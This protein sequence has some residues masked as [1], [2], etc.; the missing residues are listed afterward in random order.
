M[1]NREVCIYSLLLIIL[2]TVFGRFLVLTN[3]ISLPS[4]GEPQT[5]LKENES[6][7]VQ[8]SRENAKLNQDIVLPAD[9]E[10]WSTTDQNKMLLKELVKEGSYSIILRIDDKQCIDCIT[11]AMKTIKIATAGSNSVRIFVLGKFQSRSSQKFYKDKFNLV[12]DFYTCEDLSIPGES[13][14]TPYFLKVDSV[15]KIKKA[16]FVVKEDENFNVKNLKELL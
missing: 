2:C 3:N 10:I 1:T 13:V 12:K 8:V 15:L 11:A 6:K 4:F 5:V 9:V 14:L 7:N 16:A